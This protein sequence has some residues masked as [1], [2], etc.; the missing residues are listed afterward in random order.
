MN[1][2]LEI[3]QLLSD[4]KAVDA[5]DKIN[6]YSGFGQVNRGVIALEAALVIL[7]RP[8]TPCSECEKE[9]KNY[10][11]PPFCKWCG[12]EFPALTSSRLDKTFNL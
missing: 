4:W 11:W 12:R 3:E 10:P 6:G 1:K 8:S 9:R 5:D 2:I 7:K